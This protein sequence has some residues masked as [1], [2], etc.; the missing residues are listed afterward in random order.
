M[1]G[2]RFTGWSED[3]FDVLLQLEG[4][5]SL[6]QREKY[7]TRREQMVRRPMIALL[8][9]VADIDERYQ[10]FSVWGYGSM[11]WWWQHQ[12]AIVRMPGRHEIGLRFDLDGLYIS[13][14]W[15]NRQLSA[16]RSAVAEDA[17]GKEFDGILGA[18]GETG[19][20]VEGDRMKRCPRGVPQDHERAGL[21]RYRTL[22]VGRPLA[23]EDWLLSVETVDR[24][25]EVFAEI[26]PL[27]TWLGR[28]VPG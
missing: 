4:E 12:G 7:R 8:N 13:A 22:S 9:D 24:V 16:Y 5:P 23:D 19:Y 21:L 18:L 20:E 10:D 6:A 17:S 2:M 1:T 26:G 11:V 15:V 3:A 28:Y 14:N 27:M 25:L